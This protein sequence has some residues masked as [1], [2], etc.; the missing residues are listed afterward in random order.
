MPETSIFSF[1]NDIFYG[2]VK[3]R[4]VTRKL[5]HSFQ[6]DK[7]LGQSNLKAFADN[8]INVAEKAKFVVKRE[9]Q[10]RLLEKEKILVASNLSFSTMC[11]RSF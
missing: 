10:N 7:I 11:S 3:L 5:I 6:N 1:F 9:E 8:K 2:S 4:M